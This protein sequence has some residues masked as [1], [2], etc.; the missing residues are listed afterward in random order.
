M[1]LSH[2][3]NDS[4]GW[5]LNL[6]NKVARVFGESKRWVW[7]AESSIP[8]KL[9]DP[10][11]PDSQIEEKQ[12]G[13]DPER[14]RNEDDYDEQQQPPPEA[15]FEDDFNGMNEMDE[16]MLAAMDVDMTLPTP[17]PIAAH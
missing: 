16:E 5:W 17:P 1:S 6:S 8:T 15:E 3:R 10:K 4:W 7:R 2:I 9:A 11:A 13:L 14:D 12:R